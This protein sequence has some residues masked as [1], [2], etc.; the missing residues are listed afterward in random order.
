VEIYF[1]NIYFKIIDCGRQR[2]VAVRQA[3]LQDPE[4]ALPSARLPA[5]TEFVGVFKKV[6]KYFLRFGNCEKI[7]K[8]RNKYEKK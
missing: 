6:S 7:H 5:K 4:K 2:W 1:V 3:L 8:L